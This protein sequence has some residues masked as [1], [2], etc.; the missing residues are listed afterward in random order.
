MP[1]RDKGVVVTGAG[2]G[3]GRA[4]ATRLAGEGARVVVN[5]LDAEAAGRVA[6]EIGGYAAPG[7]A[8]GEQGVAAL[9]DAARRHL[10]GIDIWFAN[11]GID[12]GRGLEATEADWAATHEVNVM[13]H[14]RAARLLV[15][16][17]VERG[18]GRFVVTASAAGLLTM[19]GSPSYSVSKHAC[20]A[21]AEWLS[22]TY[23]HRGVVVQAICP[24]GV[25]TRMLDDAG[26]L[27][28]LLSHDPA[29]APEDVAEA[30]WQ[31]LHDDRFL[32]L[33]HPQVTSY[34]LHRA[35][36]TD[37]WLHGM[38]KLQRRLEEQEAIR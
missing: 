35:A 13:A 21:F 30:T 7:D 29:V 20:V 17:W 3:I 24:Q 27:Q 36:D 9:V 12:R 5:D 19:L 38:N 23:R 6:E 25:R 37:R 10:G 34:Y 26:P 14:V 1:V 32:I 22:A 4:L 15:P 18:S 16:G 28:E 11:A 31:A 8:A 33:P 2:H